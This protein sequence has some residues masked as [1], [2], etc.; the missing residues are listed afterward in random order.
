MMA[1]INVQNLA[2]QQIGQR[3][4]IYAYYRTSD[5]ALTLVERRDPDA[6]CIPA[7]EKLGIEYVDRRH[8]PIPD[9]LTEYLDRVQE[10]IVAA[11][12]QVFEETGK[13][14][15]TRHCAAQLSSAEIQAELDNDYQRVTE[16]VHDEELPAGDIMLYCQHCH[17]QTQHTETQTLPGGYPLLECVI[18]DGGRIQ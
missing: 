2:R 5:E 8:Q 17:R 16:I 13:L 4:D 7:D 14:R 3:Q 12:Q 9:N 1:L 6:K 11:M 10:G 18:C 15:A